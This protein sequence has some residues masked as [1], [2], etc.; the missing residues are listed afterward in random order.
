M[1]RRVML[2]CLSMAAS[3]VLAIAG[4]SV[5]TVTDYGAV[6]DGGTLNTIVIQH[7]IDTCASL[8]GGTV[9]VPSGVF[10]SGTL[11]LRSNVRLE[12]L[13]GAVLKGSQ[14]LSDYSLDGNPAGLIYT[15]EAENVTITGPGTIDGNGDAFMDLT[16][17]KSIDSAGKAWTRQ[18]SRFREVPSGIGD[19]PAV[20]KDRP[21]QMII[22]SRCR[23]VVIRDLLITNSPFWTVHCADC[24]GVLMSVVQQCPCLRLRHTNGR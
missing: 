24:D 5:F 6:G 3:G 23:N 22:F 17:A 9:V 14:R 11:R 19:G 2:V 4:T 15:E 20:P 10:L 16:H 7:L 18:K 13:S 21:F 8:H 1:N 12:I